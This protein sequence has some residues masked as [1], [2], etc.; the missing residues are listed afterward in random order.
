MLLF[1]AILEFFD[2]LEP[3]SHG[4]N[5]DTIDTTSLELHQIVLL[6]ILCKKWLHFFWVKDVLGSLMSNHAWR[7]STC[8]WSLFSTSRDVFLSQARHT[9]TWTSN[10]NPLESVSSTAKQCIFCPPKELHFFL[11]FSSQRRRVPNSI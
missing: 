2:F 9:I 1:W 6:S 10:T 5:F 7:S 4:L 11:S 8:L 3:D